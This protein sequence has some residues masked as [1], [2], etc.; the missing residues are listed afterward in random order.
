M[1]KGEWMFA[2]GV[3]AI[4][5]WNVLHVFNQ[6]Q[7][8]TSPTPHAATHARKNEEQDHGRGHANLEPRSK[9]TRDTIGALVKAKTYKPP[10]LVQHNSHYSR[11]EAIR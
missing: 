3:D 1:G 4:V 5:G 8:P 10:H 9:K 7:K 6:K 2:G 11:Q